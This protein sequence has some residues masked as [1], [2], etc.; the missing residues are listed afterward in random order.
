MTSI[1]FLRVARTLL[2]YYRVSGQDMEQVIS[3]AWVAHILVKYLEN[4]K[5]H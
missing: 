1:C 3:T 5:T 4:T 2:R